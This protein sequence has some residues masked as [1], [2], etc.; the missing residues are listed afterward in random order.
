MRCDRPID[1]SAI[2]DIL[3][4][5]TALYARDVAEGETL[6]HYV[7]RPDRH[8]G[9]CDL[10]VISCTGFAIK[11]DRVWLRVPFDLTHPV[12]VYRNGLGCRS[13]V[14]ETGSRSE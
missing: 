6:N 1:R 8:G 4:D 11:C 5:L 13:F 10:V 2:S 9:Q 14:N 3:S 12:G 7:P